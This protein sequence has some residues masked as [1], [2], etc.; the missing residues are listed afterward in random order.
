MAI[1]ATALDSSG[2]VLRVA[3]GSG[4]LSWSDTG[5]IDGIFDLNGNVSEWVTGIRLVYG[6]LLLLTFLM[7]VPCF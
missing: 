2:R 1:P 7:Y 4:P 6:E 5:T 3:T